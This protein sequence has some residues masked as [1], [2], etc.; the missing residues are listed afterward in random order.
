MKYKKRKTYLENSL[1]LVLLFFLYSCSNDYNSTDSNYY[2]SSDSLQIYLDSSRNEHYNTALRKDFISKGIFFLEKHP[3]KDSLLND[4][5]LRF[6][7]SA[8]LINDFDF[9]ESIS[10]KSIKT[11]K[12]I[13]DTFRLAKAYRYKGYFLDDLGL[14]I[15]AYDYYIKSKGL[16]L[17]INDSLNWAQVIFQIASIEEDIH[18]YSKAEN[19]IFETLKIFN[20]ND[21]DR[22]LTCSY[23]LIANVYSHYKDY[24]KSIEFY[25]KSI[26][27]TNIEDSLS[28]SAYYNNIATLFIEKKEWKK[29]IYYFNKSLE[30]DNLISIDYKSYLRTLD[31]LTYVQYKKSKKNPEETFQKNYIKKLSIKDTA[32]VISNRLR[33]SEF[34]TENNKYKQ[35]IESAKKALTFSKL[36]HNDELT[37]KSLATII[38]IDT[39]NS[40]KYTKNLITLKDSINLEDRKVRNKLARIRMET[41]EYINKAEVLK[42]RYYTLISIIVFLLLLFLIVY[43]YSKQRIRINTLLEEQKYKD[44]VRD[45]LEKEKENILEAKK[46]I[47]S[48]I[49]KEL[50]DNILSQLFAVRLNL[51]SLN[52][53][54]NKED[55]SSRQIY[56]DAIVGIE[57]SLREVSHQLKQTMDSNL[58]KA[59]ESLLKNTMLS[60]NIKY[61][62]SNSFTA[63]EVIESKDKI[64]LY[65]VFQEIF[66]NIIKHSKASNIEVVFTGD[67]SNLNCLIVDDGIGFKTNRIK[68]GIGLDNI[69]ER[70]SEIN[71]TLKIDSKPNNGTSISFSINIEENENG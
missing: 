44:E 1:I 66:T 64:T 57:N 16:F 19:D 42:K 25:N 55:I 33:L 13:D 18:Q 3:H 40:I 36:S 35:A 28:Y 27:Y 49:S 17:A 51:D 48:N 46:V 32:G 24:D 23:D 21:D 63:W 20:K 52:N 7:Y 10:E 12:S 50:H 56:I 37:L 6:S 45:I 47:R 69:K 14:K 29:A 59:I 26:K 8:Y 30:F 22:Y 2:I 71:S 68:G 61:S 39:V 53:S 41:D 5:Y 54:D 15:E 43:F 38:N 4:F 65:R 67:N 34:Y 31:N 70:L 58:L 60:N 9:F 62:I 11:S